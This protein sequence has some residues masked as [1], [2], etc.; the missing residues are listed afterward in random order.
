MRTI[1]LQNYQTTSVHTWPCVEAYKGE[2]TPECVYA[3]P[4]VEIFWSTF[5]IQ[6]VYP[7]GTVLVV[8]LPDLSWNSLNALVVKNSCNKLFPTVPLMYNQVVGSW[9]EQLSL[10][11]VAPRSFSAGNGDL[12]GAFFQRLTGVP[13]QNTFSNVLWI[14][15]ALEVDNEDP[16]WLLMLENTRKFQVLHWLL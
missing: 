7:R 9:E 3:E 13:N 12:R 2:E 10:K 6:D 5:L 14:V 8:T 4:A 1:S 15:C 11:Q 16:G